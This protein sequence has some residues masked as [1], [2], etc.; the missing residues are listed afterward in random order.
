MNDSTMKPDPESVGRAEEHASKPDTAGAG[1]YLTFNLADELYGL[2]ILRVREIIG[3]MDITPVPQ[4]QT[5]VKGLLNLRGRVIPALDLRLKFGLAE[6]DYSDRTAIIVLEIS[7]HTGP[8][9]MGIV[10]DTVSEVIHIGAEDIEPAPEFGAGLRTE[11]ILGV[12]K[13]KGRV[14]ILLDIG[15]VLTGETLILAGGL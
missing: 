1:T 8:V 12:A 2:D 3:M 7:L 10:V 5:F 15:H 6:I 11:Y 4:T 13:I 9:Q 14:I